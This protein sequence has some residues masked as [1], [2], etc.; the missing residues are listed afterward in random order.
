MPRPLAALLALALSIPAHAT[1][2]AVV[3]SRDGIAVA[4]DSRLTFLGSQCD[5][6]FKILIP[7]NPAR[8]LAVV[9][10]DSVFVPPPP[11][12]ADPCRYLETAP[13]LL[14]IN[15]VVAAALAKSGPQIST[16]A[17]SQA[18]LSAVRAFARRFPGVL[19]PY[20]ARDIFSVVLVSFN[21]A[22]KSTILRNFVLRIDASG[23]HASTARLTETTLDSRSPRDVWVYGETAWMSSTVYNGPGRHFLDPSTLAFLADRRPLADVPLLEAA[24]VAG[25]IVEAAV[26][27]AQ[28]NPPPSGIGGQVHVIAIGPEL[29]P[30]PLPWRS[31]LTPQPGFLRPIQ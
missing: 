9:T 1:L 18:C 6:A 12:N 25:N 2:V 13:R 8:T 16:A 5:G 26:R 15:A 29:Q 7:S 3:P 17:I 20:A 11:A 10:G 19:K 14:D 30:Q 21:P 31:E 28:T 22:S 24:A 23:L 27:T 4:A